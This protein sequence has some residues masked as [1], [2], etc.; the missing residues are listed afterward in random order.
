MKT[1]QIGQMTVDRIS[2]ED[3]TALDPTWLFP[4]LEPAALQRFAADFSP[5]F[6]E[7]DKL[8]I[9]SHS[10]VLRTRSRT[11]LVDTC[12]GNH[13][14]RLTMP[15]THMLAR[16]DYME[17]LARVGLRLEDIDIVLCTH[18]HADHVG[19]NTRLDNGRW[20]PTFPNARYLMTRTDFDY[21]AGLHA[22]GPP[23]PVNHGSWIDS[24]LPV[25]DAGQVDLVDTDHQV[26]QHL[27]DQVWLEPSPGHTLGHVCVHAS[28]GGHR[29]IFTGD[30]FHHPIQFQESGL[31]CIGDREPEIAT[32]TRRR[33]FESVADTGCVVFPAHFPPPTAGTIHARGDWFRWQ[34]RE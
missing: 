7:G 33:I 30:A 27:D 2:E 15:W 5:S 23:K 12:N 28:S 13:K 8:F 16:Q 21:F 26:V 17:N 1:Q 22:S 14:S 29:C 18:L 32:R 19:W 20:V 9:S 24:I 11:I 10:F 4:N 6:V 34:F 25:V 3:L 31:I